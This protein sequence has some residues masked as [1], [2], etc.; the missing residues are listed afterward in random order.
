MVICDG[1]CCFEMR[2]VHYVGLEEDDFQVPMVDTLVR[3]ALA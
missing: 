2:Y 1:D 3:N